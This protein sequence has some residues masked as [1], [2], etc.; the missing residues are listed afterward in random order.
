MDI[1]TIVITAGVALLF[2]FNLFH[3]YYHHHVNNITVIL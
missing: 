3:Q 1:V 2:L